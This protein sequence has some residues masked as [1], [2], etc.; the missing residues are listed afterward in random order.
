MSLKLN[1]YFDQWIEWI[2]FEKRLSQNTVD[3]YKRDLKFFLEFL[4]SFYNKDIVVEDVAKLNEEDLTSWFFLRLE[5]GSSHRSN[6]RALS[7]MKSFFTFLKKKKKISN[8]KFLRLRA[9]KFE[10]SLPRPLSNGQIKNIVKAVCSEKVRWISMRNLSAILLM[11]GY[12]LRISEVINL[13]YNNLKVS[14]LKILG[15]G[16]KYRIIP[17]S[18]LLLN[19]IKRMI[20]E[21]PHKIDENEFVFLGKR[22]RKIKASIMQKLIREL[23]YKLMLPDNTTPHS[24]RHTF[25]TELLEN[26]VD[27]RSIQELLG[28]S[29][30]TSTQKY[31]S[32]SSERLKTVINK[33]HPRSK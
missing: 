26:M 3:S 20:F 15:K 25:A 22:G 31:T 16:G 17:I 5:K 10:D 8:S 18:D 4:E 27:L 29:S 32:I 28:H 12:G 19:F 33:F 2:K 13:K 1:E 11:W 24:L 21:C 30:L 7:S 23:R 6:A 9:P 14:D